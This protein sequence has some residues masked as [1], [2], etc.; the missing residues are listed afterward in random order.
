MVKHVMT[1][2]NAQVIVPVQVWRPVRI[3]WGVTSA[4]VRQVR[5]L[6]FYLCTDYTI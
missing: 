4:G 3:Q 6:S 2:M 5:E 1:P